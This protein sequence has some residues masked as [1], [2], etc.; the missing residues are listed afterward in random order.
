MNPPKWRF[1]RLF[2]CSKSC[3]SDFVGS[4]HEYD[5]AALS[6]D[7]PGKAI[8]HT[9]RDCCGSRP[10][11]GCNLLSLLNFWGFHIYIVGKIKFKLYFQV[12]LA[13]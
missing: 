9:P 12:P 3:F 4:S 2:S 5:L 10:A 1:R 8:I 11:V 13:K 6:K 7:S